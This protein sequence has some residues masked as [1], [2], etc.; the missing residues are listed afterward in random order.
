MVLQDEEF[1]FERDEEK[2][3]IRISQPD[4][5]DLE[6]L[7]IIELNSPVLDMTM[8]M[9]SIRRGRKGEIHN[10]VTLEECKKRLAMLP[11]RVIKKTLA[12]CTNLY[13]N[14]EVENRQD[15]HRHF[16]YR[17][18]GIRYP[19]QTETV[20]LETFFLTVKTRR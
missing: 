8:D 2:L 10:G 18:P 4:E 5:G 15:P 16:K 19:R 17:F 11:E 1:P 9:N 12:N 14:V 3:F 7:E 13:F 20:A 6:E